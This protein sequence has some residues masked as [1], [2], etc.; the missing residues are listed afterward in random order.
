MHIKPLTSAE[1]P[2][3]AIALASAFQGD[4][5]YT[6][7]VPDAEQRR[8]WLPVIKREVL[9]NTQPLGHTYAAFSP[10]GAVAGVMALT[11]PG[12]FP[13]PWWAN[14]RLFWNVLLRPTPWCPRL[15]PLWPLRRYAATFDEIHLRE[16]HWYVDVVGIAPEFQG[17][18]L[19]KRLL[20]MAIELAQGSQHPLWLETQTAA[21]VDFYAALGFR[22][23]VQRQPA[24]GGPPTWGMLRES[25]R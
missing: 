14:A 22:V 21:N 13:H 3:A 16:P 10:R 19:G 1:L 6:F 20:N 24:P 8:R 23:T 15:S 12:H 7:V 5:L 2:A 17:Q 25:D 9:R 18:G 4:P 11:P